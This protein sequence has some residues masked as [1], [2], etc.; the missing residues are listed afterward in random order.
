MDWG[1]KPEKAKVGGNPLARKSPRGGASG[2]QDAEKRLA[3]ALEQQVA[4]SEILRVI[5][6]SR[7]DVQPAFD[8]IVA[9]ALKLCRASSAN[10]YT[11]D[12][13]LV[14]LETIVTGNPV[15][16]EALR[17]IFP[18]PP[19]TLRS[20]V[21]SRHQPKAGGIP[22]RHSGVRTASTLPCQRHP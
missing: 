11:Y 1:A 2:G 14:H 5:S 9:A 18:R 15:P 7:T 21:R 13:E 3:E 12:G 16:V 17:Q 6:Q 22:E 10:V 19:A 4:T 8:T 20:C